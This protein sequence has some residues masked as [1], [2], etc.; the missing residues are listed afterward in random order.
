M[1]RCNCKIVHFLPRYS[2][3]EHLFILNLILFPCKQKKL[4]KKH[5]NLGQNVENFNTSAGAEEE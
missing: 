4:E 2:V 3:V 5:G 1:L